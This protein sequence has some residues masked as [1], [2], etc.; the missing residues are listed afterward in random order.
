MLRGQEIISTCDFSI[1]QEGLDLFQLKCINSD[2]QSFYTQRCKEQTA[3]L[4][5]LDFG[6]ENE[7]GTFISDVGMQFEE[8]EASISIPTGNSGINLSSQ[9]SV[10]VYFRAFFPSDYENSAEYNILPVVK[11]LNL[12]F[13]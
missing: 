3:F 4:T 6:N 10:S 7:L 5:N 2:S 8:N 9:N 12:F 13:L 1:P 11:N